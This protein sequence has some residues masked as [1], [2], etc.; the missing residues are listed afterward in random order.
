MVPGVA[1]DVKLTWNSVASPASVGTSRFDSL[2]N[3]FFGEREAIRLAF[4]DTGTTVFEQST[5]HQSFASPQ[6]VDH[7]AAY[8]GMA[9]LAKDADAIDRVMSQH[10]DC[11]DFGLDDGLRLA[12]ARLAHKSGNSSIPSAAIA[13]SEHDALRA[14]S[15]GDDFWQT[16]AVANRPGRMYA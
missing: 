13:V 7:T 16:M 11:S 12:K 5:P 3:L 4:D 8:L 2:N 14:L 1:S 15:I 10:L 9:E 6:A